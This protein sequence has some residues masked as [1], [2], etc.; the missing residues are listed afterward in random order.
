M[1]SRLKVICIFFIVLT[2]WS[3]TPTKTETNQPKSSIG[4]QIDQ[5]VELMSILARIA[6]FEEYSHEA[7]PNY[8]R[9]IDQYFQ[10][11]KEHEVIML[12][13]EL[14]DST[15]L[16]Y[17]ALMIMAV[18]LDEDSVTQPSVEIGEITRQDDRWP[19]K[20]LDLFFDQLDDFYVKS[21]FQTFFTNHQALYDSTTTR[22]GTI[23]SKVNIDWFDDFLGVTDAEFRIILG[24]GNGYGNY[25]PKFQRTKNKPIFYSILGCTEADEAGLPLFYEEDFTETMVHEFLHSY[26]NPALKKYE[27]ELE[28]FGQTIYGLSKSKMNKLA[29]GDWQTVVNETL[30][31]AL[32]IQYLQ[33]H[34]DDSNAAKITGMMQLKQGFYWMPIV[35]QIVEEYRE[36]WNPEDNIDLLVQQLIL[37]VNQDSIAVQSSKDNFLS[38]KGKVVSVAPFKN[39]DTLVDSSVSSIS[40]TFSKPLVPGMFSFGPGQLGFDHYPKY[41]NEDSIFTLSKDFKT[42]TINEIQLEPDKIYQMKLNGSWYFTQDGHPCEDYILNFRTARE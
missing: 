1:K 12:L 22:F 21:N 23:T 20:E 9:D 29:Y 15:G 42:I 6:G 4:I 13:Q 19:T 35:L 30:V 31:R 26:V 3:C 28:P 37:R 33:Q 38:D 40:F 8:V 25:G 17:D 39:G 5:R 36:N 41:P 24:V 14:R 18:H 32:V 11:F 2:I 16:G 27:N 7:L 34:S 10:T